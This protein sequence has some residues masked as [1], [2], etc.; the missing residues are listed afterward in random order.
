MFLG[1]DVFVSVLII[2]FREEKNDLI[3]YIKD[4]SCFVLFYVRGWLVG[5]M[6]SLQEYVTLKPCMDGRWSL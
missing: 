4:I 2:F 1:D 3:V 6:F 5:Y